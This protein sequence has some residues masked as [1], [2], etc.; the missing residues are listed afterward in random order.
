MWREGKWN[1]VNPIL[2]NK[3]GIKLY[4]IEEAK[5]ETH[6]HGIFLNN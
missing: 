6:W 4:A 1:A 5:N 3:T 2:L